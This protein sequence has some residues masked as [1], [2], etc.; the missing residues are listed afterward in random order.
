MSDKTITF[1]DY[2]TIGQLG[3]SAT[4]AR[5]AGVRHPIGYLE[6]QAASGGSPTFTVSIQHSINAQSWT[7][8]MEFAQRATAGY[9]YKVMS[10]TALLQEHVL[11]YVRANVQVGGTTPSF[12]GTICKL[13][14]SDSHT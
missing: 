1:F 4:F 2:S 13:F 12:V 7:P 6:V 3:N 10:S 14:F 9:E 11:P 5:Q 8:L